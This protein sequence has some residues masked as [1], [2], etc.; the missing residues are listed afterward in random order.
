MGRPG[1]FKRLKS[2]VVLAFLDRCI[3]GVEADLATTRE[4]L[5][6]AE[7]SQRVNGPYAADGLTGDIAELR[8]REEGLLEELAYVEG[9]KASLLDRDCACPSIP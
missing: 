8:R 7:E 1:L 4:H 9:R 2:A 6:D 3:H 5:L